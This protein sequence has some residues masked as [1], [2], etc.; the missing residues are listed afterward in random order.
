MNDQKFRY[1]YVDGYEYVSC[2]Y[3]CVEDWIWMTRNLHVHM[4]MGMGMHHVYMHVW[5]I[6]YG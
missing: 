6:G 5:M 1:T 3:A 2:V 4:W